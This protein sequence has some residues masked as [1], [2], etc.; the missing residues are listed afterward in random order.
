MTNLRYKKFNRLKR[1]MA[2]GIGM[3][4]VLLV[5][6]IGAGYLI[7]QEV[8]TTYTEN[9]MALQSAGFD[10]IITTPGVLSDRLFI[11]LTIT[12][13]IGAGIIF[14]ILLKAIYEISE[15]SDLR[16]Q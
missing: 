2:L 4:L 8:V 3:F 14:P 13:L 5:F 6:C 7:H 10:N 15:L 12:P 16:D 11:L 1:L 9:Y